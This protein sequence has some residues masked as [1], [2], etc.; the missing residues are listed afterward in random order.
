MARPR[1]AAALVAQPFSD[2]SIVGSP[3]IHCALQV[4]AKNDIRAWPRLAAL[5]ESPK[6]PAGSRHFKRNNLI[7]LSGFRL[8]LS[9]T[10][11]CD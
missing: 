3:E 10:G 8:S 7:V 9:P 5:F 1:P 6:A 11:N 2:Y 4:V